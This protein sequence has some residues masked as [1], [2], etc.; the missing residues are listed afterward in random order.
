MD[1]LK[2][3]DKIITTL[4]I[5]RETWKCA[6]IW[7]VKHNKRWSQLVTDLIREKKDIMAQNEATK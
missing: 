2:G 6:K 4:Y 3:S 1:A 5:D 7:C